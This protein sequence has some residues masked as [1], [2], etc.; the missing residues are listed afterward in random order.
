MDNVLTYMTF[1]PLAG[2]VVVLLLPSNNAPI[3]LTSVFMA[4]PHYAGL[5]QF[6]AGILSFRQKLW[7]GTLDR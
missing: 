5:Q 7:R 6:P 3:K 4:H 2:A 1:I